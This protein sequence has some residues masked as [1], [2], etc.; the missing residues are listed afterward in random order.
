MGNYFEVN[1]I[2]GISF[3]LA[4]VFHW[5]DLATFQIVGMKCLGKKLS[6]S[7]WSSEPDNK[8]NCGFHTVCRVK[9]MR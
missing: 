9:D 2:S 7:A 5:N 3:E 6:M 8:M 4:K 1:P